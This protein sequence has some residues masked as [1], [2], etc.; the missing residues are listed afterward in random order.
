MLAASLEQK[1]RETNAQNEVKKLFD[2]KTLAGLVLMWLTELAKA[3]KPKQYGCF[4]LNLLKKKINHN[5]AKKN[6]IHV[7]NQP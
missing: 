6:G 1:K 4:W 2:F 7:F 5:L 3:I